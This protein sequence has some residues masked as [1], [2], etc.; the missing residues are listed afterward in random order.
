MARLRLLLAE[1]ADQGNWARTAVNCTDELVAG[2][3]ALNGTTAWAVGV[4][5][6]TARAA[7]ACQN[8]A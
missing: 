4:R 8:D 3:E 6:Q 1:V 5:G 2:A 7:S